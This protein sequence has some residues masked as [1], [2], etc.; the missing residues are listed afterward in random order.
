M[1]PLF[2]KPF[3]TSDDS[4]TALSMGCG[5][6]IGYAGFERSVATVRRAF[7]LGIRYFDTSP[8]YR[9]GNS[10]AIVGEALEGIQEKHLLATKIGHFKEPRHFRSVEAMQ[11]QFRENLRL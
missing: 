6:P 8:L 3:G 11:A 4:C 2:H 5:F 10:Q 1:T 7:E 9:F